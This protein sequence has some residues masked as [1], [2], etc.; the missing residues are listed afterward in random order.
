MLQI[1][2]Y[3]NLELPAKSDDWG[4]GT[5]ITIFDE[6]NVVADEVVYTFQTGQYPSSGP[7]LSLICQN[8]VVCFSKSV[9]QKHYIYIQKLTE[10]AGDR[11]MVLEQH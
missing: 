4:Y 1:D 2:Y 8:K 11:V 10:K 7:V 9:N 5:E 3:F 6:D